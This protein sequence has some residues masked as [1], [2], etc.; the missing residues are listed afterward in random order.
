MNAINICKG[1][2]AQKEKGVKFKQLIANVTSAEAQFI[3]VGNP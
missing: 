2:G 1:I 3:A